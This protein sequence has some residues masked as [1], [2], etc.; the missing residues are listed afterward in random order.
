MKLG[1]QGVK[2]PQVHGGARP[3]S[4]AAIVGTG[5][6]VQS[7]TSG[8]FCCSIRAGR[9]AEDRADL[10]GA[11]TTRGGFTALGPF[12]QCSTAFVGGERN[13]NKPL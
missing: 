4:A 1:E 8:F 5:G 6:T 12:L 3:P 2:K 10:P 13:Y 9:A 11:Q 7:G